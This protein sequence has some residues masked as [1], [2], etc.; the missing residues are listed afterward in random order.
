M[1]LMM[2]SLLMRMIMRLTVVKEVKEEANTPDNLMKAYE[3][4]LVVKVIR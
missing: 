3:D 4:A 2:L 1:W